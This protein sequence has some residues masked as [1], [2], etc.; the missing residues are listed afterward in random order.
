[1]P[2][3]ETKIL[4]DFLLAPAPL[5]DFTTLRDFTDIFPRAHRSSPAVQE[6]YRELQHIRDRDIELIR[7]DIIDE[8][9]RSKQLRREYARERRHVDDATV[10]GLDPIALQMEQELSSQSRKKPHT[11][12][13]VHSDIEEACQTLE[14]QIA[15]IEQEN[16]RALAEVKD[17]I[18][19]LSEL[20]HGRF[21]PSSS[22]EIIG[23]EVM[24]TLKQLEAVCDKP[25]G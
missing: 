11:L 13:T 18:G 25:A 7:Q 1:M 16:R 2:S 19:A 6:I 23:E 24:A 4:G 12:Q 17:V 5:R 10:A 9:K 20:R 21:A 8:V 14:A 15:E 3:Q 22:G